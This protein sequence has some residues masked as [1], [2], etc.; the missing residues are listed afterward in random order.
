MKPPNCVC[1]HCFALI[2]GLRRVERPF[3]GTAHAPGPTC[4]PAMD[5]KTS[6][7]LW[8][9]AW[10]RWLYGIYNAEEGMFFVVKSAPRT[11]ISVNM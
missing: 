4:N 10:E 7:D 8:K 5:T 3:D 1:V 9:H 6:A 11:S 2:A